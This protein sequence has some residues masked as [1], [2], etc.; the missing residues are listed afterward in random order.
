MEIIWILAILW[1]LGVIFEDSDK[2]KRKKLIEKCVRK[3]YPV[4]IEKRRQKILEDDYGNVLVAA[5][6][7]ELQYFVVKVLKPFVEKDKKLFKDIDVETLSQEVDNT[8]LE[9]AQQKN[10]LF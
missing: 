8:I 1:I 9:I 10:K 3:H 7:K 4:L 2:T 6:E 5:W